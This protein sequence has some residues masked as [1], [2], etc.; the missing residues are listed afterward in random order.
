M[1]LH[2]EMS[3]IYLKVTKEVLKRGS[4]N[5]HFLSFKNLSPGQFLGELDS[6]NYH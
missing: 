1:L 3:N 6:R 5:V 2:K 4:Q